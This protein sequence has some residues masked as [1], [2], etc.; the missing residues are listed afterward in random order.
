MNVASAFLPIA[1]LTKKQ[2][3][4]VFHGILKEYG[5]WAILMMIF[6]LPAEG[7]KTTPLHSFAK[8]EMGLAI[9]FS[10]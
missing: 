7:M 5:W 3:S 2:S 1:I 4:V 10:I 8:I 6:T 9:L